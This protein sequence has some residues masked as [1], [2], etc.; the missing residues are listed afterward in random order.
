MSPEHVAKIESLSERQSRKPKLGAPGIRLA[1]LPVSDRVE[2]L[3]QL[4]AALLKEIQ[5]LARDKAFT[6]SSG[7]LRS[8][9]VA[10]GIDFNEEVRQFEIGLIKLGH[11]HAGRSQATAA[12]LLGLKPT[13]L[14]SK[15]KMLGIEY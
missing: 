13:T 1:E 6:D 2:R 4:A 15:I 7:Q 8:L 11:N 14:N 3:V 5:I 9:D 10:G 12:R